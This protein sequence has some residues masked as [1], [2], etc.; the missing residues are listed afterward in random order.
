MLSV[1]GSLA[2]ASF[3]LILI[4]AMPDR[5]LRLFVTNPTT[6]EAGLNYL[7]FIRFSYLPYAVSLASMTALRAIGLSRPPMLIGSLAVL[8]NTA[9]NYLLIFGRFGFPELGARGAGLATLI[10]R[11]LEMILYLVLI[12]RGRHYFTSQFDA[13][14]SLNRQILSRAIGRVI[15]L[16]SNELFW[17]LGIATLFWTYAQVDE[18]RIAS[19]VI[20]EM[21]GNIN[22]IIFN[23]L[24]AAV[25]VFVGTRLGSGR[26]AEAK[27]NAGR[28]MTLAAVCSL[29]CGVIVFALSAYIPNLFNVIDEIRHS[30][31]QMLR[32]NACLYAVITLNVSIFFIL[33]IGGETRS[34]LVI[35]SGCMWLIVIP[36]AI[37]L[38][39]LAQPTMV[40]FYLALQSLEL[41]KLLLGAWFYRRGRWIRNLT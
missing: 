33:R 30:A 36:I 18:P 40:M 37:A 23:G 41:F 6:I 11:C 34:T 3:F 38:S 14:R 13:I 2:T 21:T 17:S 9:L 31:S 26:F 39:Q 22:F 5:I 19:L 32:I 35:D 16:I 10:A 27:A 25:S 1:G 20:V 29:S 15:P 28:L 12:L 4:S 7:V 8:L 24:G